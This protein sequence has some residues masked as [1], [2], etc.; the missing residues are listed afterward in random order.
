MKVSSVDAAMA[1]LHETASRTS[2]RT[3]AVASNLA[4]VD[5]PGYRALDVEFPELSLS[6]GT[7]RRTDVEHLR[8]DDEPRL[9]GVLVE[10][11]VVRVR[12]DG[13]TVDID[14]EMTLLAMLQG[15]Y[16]ASTA[17]IR[18]RFALWLYAVTDGRR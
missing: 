18:K 4:N 10:A 17:M 14:R 1:A 8:A 15:R 3:E 7:L 12:Q 9:R 2:R 13:N 6:G 5:T 11:P 16:R